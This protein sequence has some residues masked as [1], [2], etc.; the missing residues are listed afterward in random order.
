MA[1]LEAQRAMCDSSETQLRKKYQHKDDLERQ[2]K[3]DP[4][5]GYLF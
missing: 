5:N 2:V 4:L 1:R 3:P